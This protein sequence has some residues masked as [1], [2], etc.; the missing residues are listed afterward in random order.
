MIAT[1]A[2]TGAQS[3][4]T[5]PR[6]FLDNRFVYVTV[7]PRAKGLSVGV[8]FAPDKQ[9][10]FDCV[11]CEVNRTLPPRDQALDIEVMG[12]ELASTLSLIQ[13][14]G[15][16]LLPQFRALPA[17]LLKLK[18]VCLSGDG[19]PTLCPVFLDAVQK[20]L[21]VR[22]L[23][24][25]PFFKVV[26]VTN[27]SALDRPQVQEAL[28]F[29]TRQD[30]IW[31]KLDGGTEEYLRKVCRTD[32]PLEKIL[33]NILLTARKRP[34]VIQSLFTSIDGEE[35][36]IVEIDAY[37]ARL[38]ELV[39]QGAQIS[40]VQI[41]S[42]TRPIFHCEC[43]HLSLRRLSQIAQTVRTRTGLKVEIF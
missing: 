3:P 33:S 14:G 16:Q 6:D 28:E 30:E 19:E 8:N 17:Q 13:Q 18:H 2:E 7:S 35:P 31:A 34:V 26:L 40:L 43:T 11:Y 38:E 39:R 37:A 12:E 4:F 23:G 5:N 25:T 32:V 22:A 24:R 29:F 21:Q 10:N 1:V 27:S 15:L 9:C 20:V 36:S 42:A 41:Y